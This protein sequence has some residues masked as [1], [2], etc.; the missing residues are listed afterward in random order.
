MV[1]R[2]IVIIHVWRD[3]MRLLRSLPLFIVGVALLSFMPASGF[4]QT[5]CPALVE[6]AITALGNNCSG[7]DRNNACYG[8]EQVQATFSEDVSPDFFTHPADRTALTTVNA[9]RTGPLDPALEQWGIAVLNV[10]ANVPNTLPGQAVTV[11]LMG[12]A[13]LENGVAV[14]DAALPGEPITVI[15]QAN[16]DLLG[17]PVLDAIIILPAIPGGTVIEADAISPDGEWLRVLYQGSPGW[18]SASAVNVTGR[19]TGLPKI[20]ADSQSPMQAFTFQ[21]GVGTSACN[22]APSLIAVQGPENLTVD[23]SVNGADIRMGSLVTLQSVSQTS[24]LIVVHEGHVE[25][26]DGLILEAGQAVLVELDDEGNI[27]SWGEP[28]PATPEELQLGGIVQRALIAVGNE[29]PTLPDDNAAC[30]P[31]V[32]HTVAP[33]ENLFRIAQRYGTSMGTILSAN[34]LSN[35]NVLF[36]GQQL[37]IPCGDLALPPPPITGDDTTPSQQTGGT[38]CSIFRATS[39]LDGLPYGLTTF[40]WD[41]APGATGY[42]VNIYNLDGGGNRLTASFETGGA[43][44]NLVADI[45]NETVGQG[46]SFAWEV[47]ALV[48]GQVAC[49]SARTNMQRSPAPPP[50]QPPAPSCNFNY[51]CEPQLGESQASCNFDC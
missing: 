19:V 18:I 9:L 8:Y 44:S 24:I 17:E 6:R 27:V 51:I 2:W 14:E 41:P 38:D 35:A 32:V 12:D 13:A 21:T 34:G 36:V 46:F 31:G 5:S 11:L 7:L 15:T 39:P 10:Q 26:A 45:T 49:T 22:E 40:Y 37:S 30:G 25:T 23:L 1:I 16:A 3:L 33:G 20:S 48:N 43:A 50:P 4:A 28:R 42:R 47:Q 29:P